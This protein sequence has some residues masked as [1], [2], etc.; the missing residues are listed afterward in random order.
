MNTKTVSITVWSKTG[1]L[2]ILP[3][4]LSSFTHLLNPA[5]FPDIFYDEGVYLRR[6]MHVLEG[7]GP[8]E[9]ATYYDHPFFGQL[10]LAGIFKLIN[11]PGSI[12]EGQTDIQTI[13][14]LYTIPRL[15][16]GALAVLDTYL[17]FKI[18]NKTYGRK[19]A[20]IAS[21]L[22]AVMPL[23]WITRRIVLD[24][25]LLPFLL[26]SILFALNS[27]SAVGTRRYRW[28][29]LSGISLSLAIFTKIPVF[30]MM[31]LVA[32]LLTRTDPGDERI[33]NIPDRFKVLAIWLIP[34]I[35][36]PFLWP[37]ESILSGNFDA[38]MR[39][40]F[41]Q[42][43][44]GDRILGLPWIT[45]A[46]ALIDPVLLLLS[47]AGGFMALIKK[48]WLVLLWSLPYIAFLALIGQTNYFHWAPLL[49]VFCIS[50]ALALT[51]GLPKI[52]TQ[53]KLPRI[54]SPLAVLSILVFGLA[55]TILVI[56]TDVS[57]SQ[58][59]A[60]AY[61]LEILKHQ[62]LDEEQTTAISNPSHAWILKYI[63]H[64]GGGLDDYRD[65]I[66]YPIKTD[67][68][69]LIADGHFRIDM[70]GEPMLADIYSRSKLITTFSNHAPQEG[71]FA[72]YP[73][74]SLLLT[75]DASNIEFRSGTEED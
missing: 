67:D 44:R 7:M 2:L 56:S 19:V 25:L 46:W 26:M 47:I 12:G 34:V 64:L 49:P 1:I 38:W 58:R 8:Q 4:A 54:L 32:H 11:F 6:A 57:I 75:T 45:W 37:L 21:I 10:L 22:F 27:T 66:F 40:V 63:Y 42:T 51:E 41:W 39:T 33:R 70:Q 23:T 72:A 69:I 24:S 59:Q 14:L 62:N 65:V 20:I 74:T 3:L 36:I 35:L 55:S 52:L 71:E 61:T 68:W 29:S 43:Q 15:V 48:N 30:T 73:F 31:P 18:A 53:I 50:S 13:E 28:V 17:I 5:G 16:M 60:L 9:T